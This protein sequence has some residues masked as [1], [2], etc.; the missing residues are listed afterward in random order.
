MLQGEKWAKLVKCPGVIGWNVNISLTP[1][2][3]CGKMP[4]YF[5]GRGGGWAQLKWPDA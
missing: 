5:P 2:G 4:K 1:D 3:Q